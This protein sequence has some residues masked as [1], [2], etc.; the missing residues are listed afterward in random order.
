[1]E[2]IEIVRLIAVV[3]FALLPVFAKLKLAIDE[4]KQKPKNETADAEKATD[5]ICED[6]DRFAAAFKAAGVT[7]RE[8]EK[9]ISEMAS[10][11]SGKTS[12]YV[13]RPSDNK[14]TYGPI[15]N[16]LPIDGGA[17]VLTARSCPN[18][19]AP[20]RGSVCDYCGSV[21][22]KEDTGSVLYLPP[23]S[24]SISFGSL[25]MFAA[26]ACVSLA[27]TESFVDAFPSSGGE[28]NEHEKN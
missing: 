19:G 12:R 22:E 20:V 17:E 9:E 28:Q 11:L 10:Y 13:F 1:M 6:M 7:A 25:P 26:S 27:G 18:C 4:R 2:A 15:R 5:K 24:P 14:P 8:A 16:E 21:F 3:S 23:L